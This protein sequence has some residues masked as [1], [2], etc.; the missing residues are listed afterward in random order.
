[1][2]EGVNL[3]ESFRGADGYGTGLEKAEMST[4]LEFIIVYHNYLIFSYNEAIRKSNSKTNMTNIEA[5]S[6]LLTAQAFNALTSLEDK[7]RAL[8]AW[9]EKLETS[10][11]LH[12]TLEIQTRKLEYIF[13][14][15]SSSGETQPR[16]IDSRCT[17][18]R[19]EPPFPSF[20][21]P[22]KSD[23]LF[24]KWEIIDQS[25][26]RLHRNITAFEH[27]HRRDI[28]SAGTGINTDAACNSIPIFP[29]TSIDDKIIVLNARMEALEA[30]NLLKATQDG[31]RDANI[32]ELSTGL[33]QEHI[34]H[35][36]DIKDLQGAVTAL[37]ETIDPV[38]P[39]IQQTLTNSEPH[40]TTTPAAQP[41]RKRS[42]YV[43]AL[44]YT[45]QAY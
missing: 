17:M 34:A 37:L 9:T 33:R 26:L 25:W 13:L 43:H 21:H 23:I 28:I 29:V 38:I 24:Q 39:G 10:D 44:P 6:N 27:K 30:A 35:G 18:S 7:F 32:D 8:F 22:N 16:L 3:R 41:A 15:G 12:R 36:K 11:F 1:M 45:C 40:Q 31:V 14:Q 19:L 4:R 42:R 5:A 2:R 20:T